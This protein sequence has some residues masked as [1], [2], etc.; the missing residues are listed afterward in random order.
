MIPAHHRGKPGVAFDAAGDLV[1]VNGTCD[2]GLRA[3]CRWREVT[4][5]PA[6][7]LAVA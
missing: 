1:K 6:G 3:K 4:F 2:R 7:A 5:A